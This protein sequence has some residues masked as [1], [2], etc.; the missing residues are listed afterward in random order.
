[1][2]YLTDHRF[3]GCVLFVACRSDNFSGLNNS[4]GIFLSW[5]TSEMIH[6]INIGRRWTFILEVVNSD[7]GPNL[8]NIL[9]LS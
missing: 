9:R 8:Q 4:I 7:L 5:T 6:A 3:L 2:F 1:M